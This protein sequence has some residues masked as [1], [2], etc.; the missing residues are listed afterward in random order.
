MDRYLRDVKVI[1][2]MRCVSTWYLVGTGRLICSTNKDL[3]LTWN[4][5]SGNLS[6]KGETG[7]ILRTLLINMCTDSGFLSKHCSHSDCVP[8]DK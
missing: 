4:Y 2:K 8:S 3:S 6:S 5:E 7:D 1:Y